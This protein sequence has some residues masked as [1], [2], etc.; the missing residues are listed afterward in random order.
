MERGDRWEDERL[1][2]ISRTQEL[3]ESSLELF[4]QSETEISFPQTTSNCTNEQILWR[5]MPTFKKTLPSA[6]DRR[7]REWISI[8]DLDELH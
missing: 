4:F 7:Y 2:P 3:V 8:H 1:G 6:V 5:E